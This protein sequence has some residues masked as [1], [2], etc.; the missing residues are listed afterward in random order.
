MT[1]PVEIYYSTRLIEEE[2]RFDDARCR[3]AQNFKEFI[4]ELLQTTLPRV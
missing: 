4:Q 2:A 3:T 1:V